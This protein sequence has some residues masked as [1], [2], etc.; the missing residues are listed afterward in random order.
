MDMNTCF[1]ARVVM[2]AS[3]FPGFYFSSYFFVN[4]LITEVIVSENQFK[5]MLKELTN[6]TIDKLPEQILN[7]Q[8]HDENKVEDKE[9]MRFTSEMFSHIDKNRV[10]VFNC[11]ALKKKIEEML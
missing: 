7:I 4:Y 10:W 8:L 9:I 1:K 2:L 3:K 6:Q 11:R 5:F